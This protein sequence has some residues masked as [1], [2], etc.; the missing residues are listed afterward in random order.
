[1]AGPGDSRMS[2]GGRERGRSGPVQGVQYGEGNAQYNYFGSV[3]QNGFVGGFERLRDVYIDPLRLVRDLD[4]AR[5]TGR[6]LLVERIEAFVRDRPRGYVVVQAEA[7][8]GKS[9]LAAQL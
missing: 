1:M 5:F 3:T 6:E 2:R 9:S 8:I 7:G 4:L